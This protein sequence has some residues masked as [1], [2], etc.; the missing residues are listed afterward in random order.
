[1]KK[2]VSKYLGKP[3]IINVVE[4]A[5]IDADAQLV[6]EAI[7]QQLEKRIAFRR[8]MKQ[9][10]QRTMRAGAQGIKVMVS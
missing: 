9:A 5:R 8:A 1:M 2:E 4:V 10:M 6:A 7:A 3:I